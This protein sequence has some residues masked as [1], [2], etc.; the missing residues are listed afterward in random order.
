MM[1]IYEPKPVI[2]SFAIGGLRASLNSNER[3]LTLEMA[4]NGRVTIRYE[5][6]P[7]LVTFLDWAMRNRMEG[8]TKCL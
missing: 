6:V 7:D 8:E 2:E 3:T 4:Y 1:Q 5:S